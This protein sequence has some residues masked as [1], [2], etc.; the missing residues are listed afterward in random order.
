[1]AQP[2]EPPP[3]RNRAA[4][5]AMDARTAASTAFTRAGF[6]DATLILRW[7][8]IAGADVARF[9]RPLRLSSGPDGGTLTLKAQSGAALFLQ[10]ES[11][12]LIERI[13]TFLG[14]PA[15]ARLRFVQGPL[16]ERPAPI[17]K[18]RVRA[19]LADDDPAHR[20]DGPESVRAA[21]LRLARWRAP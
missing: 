2:A 21:L 20:F 11:R 7:A 14:R 5:L 6:A 4:L 10:H 17:V 16:V 18:K 8:E 19:A 1:M 3:R 13:N 15:V 9:A 12:S